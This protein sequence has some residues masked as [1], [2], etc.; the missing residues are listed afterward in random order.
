VG[1]DR[2]PDTG[3]RLRC[4]CCGPSF[5]PSQWHD[6]YSAI[7]QR[8]KGIKLNKLFEK[9]FTAIDLFSGAGGLSLGLKS[10]GWSVK[11]A[12]KSNESAIETYALNL[13]DVEHLYDDVREVNF[14]EFKG[15]DL[16]WSLK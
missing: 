16:V 2:N 14:K 3:P 13:P 12:L 11:A 8:K 5:D 15:L 9:N 4:S 6:Y 7:N 10:A 1:V